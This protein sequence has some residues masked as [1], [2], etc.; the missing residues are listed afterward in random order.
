MKLQM[1][2]SIIAFALVAAVLVASVFVPVA[3][4]ACAEDQVVGYIFED[5]IEGS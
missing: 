1:R 3:G 2:K 4:N 5:L